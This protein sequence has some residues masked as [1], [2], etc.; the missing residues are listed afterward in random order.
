MLR[1]NAHRRLTRP[2]SRWL[3]RCRNR[4]AV[5]GR[6]RGPDDQAQALTA[7]GRAVRA[8][9]RLARLA[10]SFFDAAV[11]DRAAENRAARR[12]WQAAWEPA[13]AQAYGVA[14]RSAWP[15]DEALPPLPAPRI[16]RAVDRQLMAL[17]MWLT[18]GQPAMARH[19]QRSPHA[20]MSFSRM[21]RWLEIGLA[22]RK[23][24]CGLDSPNQVPEKLEYDYELTDLQRAFGQP[25]EPPAVSGLVAVPVVTPASPG[26]GLGNQQ[27]RMKKISF[28]SRLCKWT[29]RICGEYT[30]IIKQSV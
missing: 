19:Q 30:K 1:H 10:P 5:R 27:A 14:P 4:S 21:A 22:F 26:N 9:Q 17:E 15:E 20:V 11:V 6:G 13:L 16:Q 23:L 7:L 29:S 28:G 25:P 2:A 12:R 3:A 8:Y 18:V 24:A